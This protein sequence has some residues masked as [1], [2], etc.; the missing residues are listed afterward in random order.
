[1]NVSTIISEFR[2]DNYIDWEQLTDAKALVFLNRAYR[3]FINE[4]RVKVN[5]D[6]FYDEW[7]ANTVDL[8]RE[9]ILQ[10][11]TDTVAWMV[12]IKWI[13]V[14]YKWDLDA[15]WDLIYKKLRLETLWNLDRDLQWYKTNQPESDPFYIISDES[16]FIYPVPTENV[17]DWIIFYW[18]W[19]PIQLALTDEEEAFKT[20]L[21]FQDLLVLGMIYHSYR[22]RWMITEKNDAKAE[23]NAEKRMAII[24]LSDR[25]NTPEISTMPNLTHL[26]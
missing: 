22:A 5:E 4:I 15:N 2:T 10:K 19:D 23:F 11:R 6:Y 1:M 18:I 25:V 8:Q 12:N 7:K 14:S 26:W 16:M 20:P 13:S 21:E 17:T 9:Y 3:D 24:E